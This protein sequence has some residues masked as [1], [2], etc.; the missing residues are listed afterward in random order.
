MKRLKPLTTC[1]KHGALY[2]RAQ[3]AKRD[4]RN[5]KQRYRCKE[6]AAAAQLKSYYANHLLHKIKSFMYSRS[7]AGK[8]RA[9]VYYREYQQTNRV[10]LRAYLR[11]YRARERGDHQPMKRYQERYQK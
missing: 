9:Q 11:A 8:R 6:C 10:R 1:G 3:V 2:K 4:V 7:A 5:G